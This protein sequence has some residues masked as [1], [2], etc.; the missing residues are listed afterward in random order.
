MSPTSY[1]I[2]RSDL[3]KLDINV[4]KTI[5]NSRREYGDFSSLFF[6]IIEIERDLVKYFRLTKYQQNI[7]QYN[8]VGKGVGSWTQYSPG[9]V[10]LKSICLSVP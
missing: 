5:Q 7:Q 10:P 9:F 1:Q 2:S 3:D 8:E 6:V 4:I